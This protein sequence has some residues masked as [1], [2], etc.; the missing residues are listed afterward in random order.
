VSVIDSYEAQLHNNRLHTDRNFGTVRYLEQLSRQ[1]I[2][3]GGT[4][5]STPVAQFKE[6]STG[7]ALNILPTI[8]ENAINMHIVLNTAEVDRF[9]TI[10]VGDGLLTATLPQ[11]SGSDKVFDVTLKSNEMVMLTSSLR[12]VVRVE[13]G[14]NDALP[15]IGDS[16]NGEKR[17]IQRIHLI[18]GQIV[19]G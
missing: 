10:N 5:L 8:T 4:T 3:Q 6:I 18:Q 15:I 16:R 9:D 13:K 11:D 1:E 14:K 7:L 17:I 19:G 12:K 2:N